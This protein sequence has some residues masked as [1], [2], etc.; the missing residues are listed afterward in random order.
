MIN[1]KIIFEDEY[2]LVIDKPAGLVVHPN[3]KR[4]PKETV[5]SWFIRRSPEIK[6]FDW[7]EPWRPGIVHRLDKD[8][9]GVL[10]L[11][12]SPQIL[13][14]LQKQWQTKEVE[15]TYLALVFGEVKQNGIINLNILRHKNRKKQTVSALKLSTQE[16]E[17]KTYYYILRHIKTKKA[18]LTLLKVKPQSGRTHQIRVHLK[19]AGYPIIGDQTYGTKPSRRLNKEWGILRQF[20]HATALKIQHPKTKKIKIFQAPLPAFLK[21]F[22]QKI[23]D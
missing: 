2:L 13:E 9:S 6:R 15:K 19:A 10:I 4:E 20:L 12:K 7:P 23:I 16:K 18:N 5:V 3:E 21:N 1:P 22:L 14:E 17:A 11:A 8:T